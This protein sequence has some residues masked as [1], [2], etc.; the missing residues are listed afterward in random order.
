MT[1]R[2]WLLAP[3]TTCGHLPASL[4]SEIL[5]KLSIIYSRVFTAFYASVIAFSIFV[6][7]SMNLSLYSG[8]T[9]PYV[10]IVLH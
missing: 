3:S 6:T 10:C 8:R 1:L 9:K 4:E 2:T 5:L 7:S